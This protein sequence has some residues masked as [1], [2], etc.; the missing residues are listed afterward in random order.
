VPA[1]AHRCARGHPV[2]HPLRASVPP[3]PFLG[4]AR[5]MSFLLTDVVLVFCLAAWITGITLSIASLLS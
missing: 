1:R 3:D 5:R 4:K 2:R